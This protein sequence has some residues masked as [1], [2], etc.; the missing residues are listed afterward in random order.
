[1]FQDEFQKKKAANLQCE[2]ETQNKSEDELFFEVVGGWNEKGRIFALGAAAH[3]YYDRPTY[4]EKNDKKSRRDY[5]K[6]FETQFKELDQ[7]KQ[8]LGEKKQGLVETKT[9]LFRTQQVLIESKRTLTETIESF[10]TFKQQ[11]EKFMQANPPR[12]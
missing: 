12:S 2:N 10:M 5:I 6:T 4:E 11:V 3:S 8:E 9:N 7:T 1:M